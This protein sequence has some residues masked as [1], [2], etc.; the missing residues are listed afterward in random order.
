M[1]GA[2]AGMAISGGAAE[3][4]DGGSMHS[5]CGRRGPRDTIS[6]GTRSRDAIS[7]ARDA[8]S[9]RDHPRDAISLDE[10]HHELGQTP[11]AARGDLRR[12][13]AR[14]EAQRCKARRGEVSLGVGGL[15][16]AELGLAGG[17][18]FGG[19][20]PQRGVFGGAPAHAPAPM[21]ELA[22]MGVGAPPPGLLTPPAQRLALNFVSSSH[23]SPPTSRLLCVQ[24]S[25]PL[26]APPGEPLRRK[27]S[28]RP[29][30]F[31]V[32]S[33]GPAAGAN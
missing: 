22:G 7:H 12:F 27:A 4:A 10:L 32:K 17:S 9:L 11:K 14:A 26:P 3:R 23:F 25:P 29:G 21:P 2:A 20:A 13:D 19:G 6:L 15:G 5:S 1:A 8:I 30:P 31:D 16:L 24:S 18:D 28:G 33:P